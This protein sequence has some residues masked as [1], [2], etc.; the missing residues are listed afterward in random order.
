MRNRVIR[1]WTNILLLFYLRVNF[2]RISSVSRKPDQLIF[3]DS[4]A[5]LYT[6]ISANVVF[7]L[8]K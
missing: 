6:V 7:L 2:K 1:S 5:A 4:N 8:W 3:S